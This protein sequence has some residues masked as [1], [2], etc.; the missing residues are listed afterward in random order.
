MIEFRTLSFAGRT[1]WSKCISFRSP[2]LILEMF[3]IWNSQF[4][5]TQWNDWLENSRI[6]FELIHTKIRFRFWTFHIVKTWRF[7]CVFTVLLFDRT[8]KVKF[9]AR[10]ASECDP[11]PKIAVSRLDKVCCATRF[12]HFSTLVFLFD[13]VPRIRVRIGELKYFIIIWVL[14]RISSIWIT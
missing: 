10:S 12:K 4:Q 7:Y 6:C 8:G 9:G 2:L 5:W 3:S 1:P 14:I 11:A 13:L